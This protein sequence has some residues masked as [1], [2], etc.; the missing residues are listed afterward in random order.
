MNDEIFMARAL[1]L[2]RSAAFTSPNPMVGCVVVR[3]GRILSEGFHAGSGTPHAEAVALEGV[4]A[5]GATLYVTLEPCVHHGK[6]PPCAPLVAASGVERV[7]I[8]QPDPD[9]RVSGRGITLLEASGVAV[10]SGVLGDEAAALN[11]AY[12]HHRKTGRAMLTL[13]LA[14]SLDGAV[15]AADGSSRW[16][17]SEETRRTVHERRS[18]ADAVMVGVGTVL[19]DDPALTARHLEG[20]RNPLR[21]VV[22]STGRTPLDARLLAEPGH[23]MIATTAKCP[24]ETQLAYKQAGAEVVVLSEEREGHGVDV[25][26]LLVMLGERDLLEVYC[27]GGPTLA[28]SLLRAGTVDRLEIHYGPLLLGGEGLR[29][30]ELGIPTIEQAQRWKLVSVQR[31]QDDFVVKLERR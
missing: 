18:S 23:V 16:I 13:K 29:L 11:A 7:V 2:A 21:I 26:P 27:E 31:H 14:T 20:A 28:A 15:A 9:P 3:N 6:T 5:T 25:D 24:H 19:A 17:T 4:D 22:D 30:G 12:L 10:T 8:A 1:D